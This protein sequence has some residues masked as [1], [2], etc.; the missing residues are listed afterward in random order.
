ML[1]LVS[2]D[3]FRF[4]AFSSNTS[5]FS[6]STFRLGLY[7][8]PD[9]ELPKPSALALSACIVDAPNARETTS[10]AMTPTPR[11]S[12]SLDDARRSR[13]FAPTPTLA[14]ARARDDIP[15]VAHLFATPRASTLD[16]R[17]RANARSERSVDV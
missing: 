12:S 3:A 8:T 11:S 15:V 16:A 13:A 7:S 14:R 6:S 17:A 1:P 5:K 9:A 2:T 10:A 4:L